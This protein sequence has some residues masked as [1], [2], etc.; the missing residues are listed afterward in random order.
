MRR[1][2]GFPKRCSAGAATMLFRRA[3]ALHLRHTAGDVYG[4]FPKFY[5][6]AAGYEVAAPNTEYVPPLRPGVQP[7][8]SQRPQFHGCDR[9]IERDHTK[10]SLVK[11]EVGIPAAYYR[12]A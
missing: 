8:R 2:G 12:V 9:R 6:N 3:G 11:V 5:G 7:L 4:G 10:C 1:H